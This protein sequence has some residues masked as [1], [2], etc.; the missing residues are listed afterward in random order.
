MIFK[1]L[2]YCSVEVNFHAGKVHMELG[3]HY[4]WFTI[5][6]TVCER[7]TWL[8]HISWLTQTGATYC[9]RVSARPRASGRAWHWP[10]IAHT[11]MWAMIFTPYAEVQRSYLYEIFGIT[12]LF[13]KVFFWLRALIHIF[14]VDDWPLSS[15]FFVSFPWITPYSLDL[16]RFS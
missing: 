10:C 13:I 9:S 7:E 16:M 15:T 11:C 2:K 8:T 4:I 12:I 6:G 14:R 1:S 3:K 5:P